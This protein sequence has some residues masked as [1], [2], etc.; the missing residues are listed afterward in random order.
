MRIVVT[1]AAGFLGS[2]LVDLLLAQ[3]HDIIGIDNFITGNESNLDHLRDNQKFTLTRHDVIEPLNL[4]GGIDRVYHLASPATP[5][6]YLPNKI[7]TLLVNSRGV[8]NLLD[9]CVAKGARFLLA[10]TSE[11]YGDAA[12]QPQSE[13]YWGNVNPI[14]IRSCYDEAK[15]FAEACTMA[16]QRERKADTR[17]V[18]IFNTY[19]PRMDPRDGRAITTFVRQALAGEPLT[20]FGDGTQ[21][22]SFNYVSDTV[23]GLAAAMEADFYEPINIGNADVVSVVQ[24]AREIIELVPGSKS[25]VSFEPRLDYD[26][27]VLRPDLMRAKQ[28]LGWSPKVARRDGL[29]KLVEDFR[30]RGIK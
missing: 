24:V 2:H 26:P 23:A 29:A 11:T 4:D 14:G 20:V 10:S 15:R 13:S 5:A 28:V 6:G 17:I 18:R 3:G 9:L 7:A 22:R 19:G 12:V 30:N 16:Y 8:C 21:A 27:R 25:K 1:G